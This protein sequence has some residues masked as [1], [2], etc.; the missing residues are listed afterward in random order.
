MKAQ[1]AEA[2]GARSAK[3]RA[4]SHF[5]K[6]PI[7]VALLRDQHGEANARKF[8][9]KEQQR[10]RRARSRRRFAFWGDVVAQIE[11]GNCDGHAG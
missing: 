11:E 6:V 8:A 5:M 10:A 4:V 2:E 9:L 1:S 7:A 3:V